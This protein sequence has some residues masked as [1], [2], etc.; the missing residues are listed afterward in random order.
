M[1]ARLIPLL[2]AVSGL[3]L[4]TTG[5]TFAYL[6]EPVTEVV[7]TQQ[8]TDGDGVGDARSSLQQ[9]SLPL[10]VLGGGVGQLTDGSRQLDDGAQQLS[11][12]LGQA[13]EGGQ[14]LAD[15]LGQLDGGVAL[16]GDG[17]SQVSG[18][19][20]EVVTRLTGFGEMQG[21][22]TGQLTSVAGTLALS[23]D[24]VS[25][26]AAAT[27]GGLVE[28][29]NTEGLGPD[30]LAQLE[31]LRDGARQLAW[32]LTDP[33]AQFVAGMSQA[34]EGSRQL[35]DGLVLLDDGGRALT[36][37]TGQLVDGVG[38]VDNVVRTITE[39]VRTATDALPQ[40]GGQDEQATQA[41]DAPVDR[42][43]WP[44][45]LIALGAV[46]LVVPAIRPLVTAN[47]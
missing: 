10:S 41:A 6:D 43:A 45:A 2:T 31:L 4:V 29:L 27:I 14:Q 13:R 34:A 38:P 46:V 28:T 33:E 15:G 18:G 11:D 20:D 8:D 42:S 30:T 7:A 19:V 25:Q 37:G 44:Y 35:L 26:Q 1:R 47:G 17:A 22:V 21:N 36:D 16:L 40:S 32:E 23:P 39:N 3:A 9:A 24:P 5:A 12:G